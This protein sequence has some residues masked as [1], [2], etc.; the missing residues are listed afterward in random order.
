MRSRKRG[1]LLPALALSLCI[2]V[3]IIVLAT[4]LSNQKSERQDITNPVGIELIDLAAPEPPAEEQAREVEKPSPKENLDV[5][6]DLFQPELTGGLGGFGD[7]GMAIDV[8]SI[9]QTAIHEN[10]V[11]ES[12]EL[13]QAPKAIV[14]V[15]PI[16][17]YGAREKSIEGAVQVRML[18]N[19]DGSVGQVQVLDARPP[20]VFEDAV[21]R[22]VPQW[23]FNPG[24][25]EGRPVAAWVVTTIQFDLD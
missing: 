21:K 22:T 2:N 5:K 6:P 23:R 9:A 24:K 18:V 15:P 4:V 13:D 7:A 16:Y 12:Y 25:I 1:F 3:A 10:L 17:P 19:P 20:G 14:R 11:F 8:G